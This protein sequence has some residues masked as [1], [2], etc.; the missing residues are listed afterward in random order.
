MKGPVMALPS[1]EE[2]LGLTIP[3]GAYELTERTHALLLK[4]AHATELFT[5]V[6]GG[7]AHPIFA[8]L[9]THCG[10]GWTFNEFLA[11]VG[12]D[13]LA[14]VVFG[15]GTFRFHRPLRVGE[16]FVVSSRMHDVTRKVGRRVGAF[17]AITIA[18]TLLDSAG[19][20]ALET[21]E[22][23]IVPRREVQEPAEPVASPP[24]IAT[25]SEA[26][27]GYQVGPILGEDIVGIMEVMNDTNPVHLDAEL[28]IA[29]GYRGPVNQGPINLAFIF[30]AMAAQ[31]GQVADI[32]SAEFTFRET[33]TEGDRLEV[34]LTGSDS[35]TLDGELHILGTG[36]AV[37]CRAE[38]ARS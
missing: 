24:T 34:R 10:M 20:A 30:N 19:E 6:S 23:Y 33:V 12:S 11:E 29:S 14:G 1:A 35:A 7:P 16:R 13:P 9:A 8:H 31:R 27:G 15:G 36:L 2:I 25:P 4:H 28:A 37:T 5:T 26:A 32:V 38:F 21:T 18:L 22:T 17:D 3:D